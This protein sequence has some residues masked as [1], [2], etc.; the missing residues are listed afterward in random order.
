VK[1]A[2]KS[3]LLAAVLMLAATT[4]Q[5]QLK[6]GKSPECRALDGTSLALFWSNDQEKFSKAV[7]YLGSFVATKREP[8]P[9]MTEE[10]LVSGLQHLGRWEADDPSPNVAKDR[11]CA[12]IVNIANELG[13]QMN[14]CYA[15]IRID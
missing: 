8:I 1:Q 7:H 3:L 12:A 15:E 10:L 2:S 11:A 13:C 6:L 14:E 5:A 4:A 9:Q